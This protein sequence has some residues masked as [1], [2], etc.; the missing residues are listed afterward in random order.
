MGHI[1]HASAATA[2]AVRTSIQRS[3][4]SFSYLTRSALHGFRQHHAQ[5]SVHLADDLPTRNFMRRQTTLNGLNFSKYTGEIT[6]SEPGSIIVNP[7]R[8]MPGLNS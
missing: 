2:C 3:Q 8:Q 5:F 1:R 4:A 7:I 6:T